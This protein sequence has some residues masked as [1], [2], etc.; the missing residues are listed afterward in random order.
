MLK[1]VILTFLILT[2]FAARVPACEEQQSAGEIIQRYLAMPH[3]KTRLPG[4]WR[5][6]R[7][8][9]LRELTAIPDKA[10]REIVSALPSVEHKQRTELIEILGRIPTRASADALIPLL[11]DPSS[12][13]RG[14]AVFSLRL[15]ASRI[16]RCGIKNVPDRAQCPPKVEGLVPHLIIAAG[17]E[18]AG[19]RNGALYALAD[20]RD[21]AAMEVFHDHLDDPDEGVRFTAACLLTEVHDDSGLHVIKRELRRLRNTQDK[22]PTEYYHHAEWI[23]VSLQRITGVGFGKIPGNPMIYSCM[24]AGEKAAKDIDSLVVAWDDWWT[25]QDKTRE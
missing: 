25:E 23:L 4:E 8:D 6:K 11:K 22:K 21:Y 14:R 17:D 19:V 10:V 7:L 15:L 18:N 12:Q 13:I 5:G 20:T 2:L 24:A 3:A 16:R 1:T 9:V